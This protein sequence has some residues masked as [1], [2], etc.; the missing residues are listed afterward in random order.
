MGANQTRQYVAANNQTIELEPYYIN[1]TVLINGKPFKIRNAMVMKKYPKKQII[2]GAPD[3]NQHWAVLQEA[4][5]KMTI[6]KYNQTTVQRYSI[7]DVGIKNNVSA[8]KPRI[9]MAPDA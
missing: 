3:L 8:I 4:T 7:N 6:G 2:L 9:A 1:F 5:G